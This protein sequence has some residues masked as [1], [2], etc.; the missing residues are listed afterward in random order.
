[1]EIAEKIAHSRTTDSGKY[2]AEDIVCSLRTLDRAFC[3]SLLLS[4]ARTRR[5]CTGFARQ[6]SLQLTLVD[7]DSL[8]LCV[9]AV[10][11]NFTR[12]TPKRRRYRLS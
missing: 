12:F 4:M 9:G 6:P 5:Y 8:G 7:K 11:R 3:S 2:A 10:L 1:M